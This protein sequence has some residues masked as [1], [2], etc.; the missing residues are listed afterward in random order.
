MALHT[1]ALQHFVPQPLQCTQHGP[2]L[3]L[4]P[5]PRHL[6]HL[7]HLLYIHLSVVARKAA[8]T[9]LF[10]LLL[11]AAFSMPSLLLRCMRMAAVTS[12]AR[13]S[14]LHGPA[15]CSSSLP[16]GWRACASHALH[17][18]GRGRQPLLAP[19]R[20]LQPPAPHVS[21]ATDSKDDASA[22]DSDRAASG[23]QV[24]TSGGGS[25]AV[26]TLPTILTLARVA[27]IPVLIA[28]ELLYPA[29]GCVCGAEVAAVTKWTLPALCVFLLV[30]ADRTASPLPSI[31][32]A[33]FML[34]QCGTG[35]PATR[36]WRPRLSLL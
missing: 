20:Q 8:H 5:H 15:A 2:R 29:A 11:V 35:R 24:S 12:G 19:T 28:G 9:H 26:F 27:A 21:F 22:A 1:L 3:S 17:P 13:R 25:A 33:G 7:R 31:H 18:A 10:V 23:A 36:L 30:P 34:E 4:H 6:R 16:G 32:G 14:L